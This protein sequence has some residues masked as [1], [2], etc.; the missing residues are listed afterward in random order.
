MFVRFG[1]GAC[2]G[3]Q[4]S[5]FFI[6]AHF[7]WFCTFW[8]FLHSNFCAFWFCKWSLPAHPIKCVLGMFNSCFQKSTFWQQ[9]D[10]SYKSELHTKSTFWQIS[11]TFAGP[12][13][14]YIYILYYSVVS[15]FHIMLKQRQR[16]GEPNGI[17]T[18]FFSSETQVWQGSISS[19]SCQMASASTSLACSALTNANIWAG[20]ECSERMPPLASS[21][22]PLWG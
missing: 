7:A 20:A 8:S 17:C 1:S 22:P 4:K 5:V 19:W 14:I 6:C 11:D 13:C 3:I 9:H 21:S 18:S 16:A 10:S 15:M 2:L 12:V